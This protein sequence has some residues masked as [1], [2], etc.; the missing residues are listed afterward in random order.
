M[1]KRRK[2]KVIWLPSDINNRL[3]TAPSP[4]TI[5]TQSQTIIAVFTANP[6]GATPVTAEIPIVKDFAGG[7]IAS[8]ITDPNS[9]L[10][11][12][13]NSGYRL[14][15]IVGKLNFIVNQNVATIAGD[16]TQ[17]LVTAGFI[18]RRI[19]P[20]LGTSLASV[21]AAGLDINV[22]TFDN[23]MDPWIWRR[24]WLLADQSVAATALNPSA[25]VTPGSNMQSYAGGNSDG[26]HVD[27]KTARVV[28]PEERLFLSVTVEGIDGAAQGAPGAVLLVGDLRVLGS[29]RSSVGNRRNASR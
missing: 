8:F 3:A 9:T 6:L 16:P 15:R 21:G 5:G 11:D 13:E 4:A 2:A 20:N 28:G 29:M 7:G 10:S 1:R 17:F 25:A 19:D 27:A 12:L 23:I 26:P 22:T 24:S 14:R 18:I